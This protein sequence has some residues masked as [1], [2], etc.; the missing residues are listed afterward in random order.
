MMAQAIVVQPAG[1]YH[2]DEQNEDLGERGRHE[3]QDQVVGCPAAWR[4][5]QNRTC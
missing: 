2:R 3:R 5:H 4:M 1:R